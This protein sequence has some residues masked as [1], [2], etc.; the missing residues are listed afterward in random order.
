MNVLNFIKQHGLDEL[1][2]KYPIKIK[3]QMVRDNVFY[4][5]LNYLTQLSDDIVSQCRGLVIKEEKPLLDEND[6][7]FSIVYNCN[8]RTEGEYVA[9]KIS[10]CK[11]SLIEECD[12]VEKIDGSFIKLFWDEGRWNFGTRSF[13]FLDETNTFVGSFLKGTRGFE[14]TTNLSIHLDEIGLPKEN[15]YMFEVTGPDITIIVE[16]KE[17]GIYILNVAN[18]ETGVFVETPEILYKALPGLKTPKTIFK[19]GSFSVEQIEIYL[20]NMDM[21]SYHSTS[22]ATGAT[23]DTTTGATDDTATDDTTTGATVAIDSIDRT[24]L[25]EGFIAYHNGTPLFKIKSSLYCKLGRGDN[26]PNVAKIFDIA[27]SHFKNKVDPEEG[28]EISPIYTDITETFDKYHNTVINATKIVG[29]TLPKEYNNIKKK[30]H[31]LVFSQAMGWHRQ[32]IP[33][34]PEHHRAVFL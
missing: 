18:T 5:T 22:D 24:K 26:I 20:N 8:R 27:L 17:Y 11:A 34:N 29:E 31:G 4:H 28:T 6:S 7:T 23:D 16:Y 14:T 30:W 15:S 25:F 1:K 13:A 33:P 9:K 3:T 32:G 10:K 21:L 2:T 19:S 12:L